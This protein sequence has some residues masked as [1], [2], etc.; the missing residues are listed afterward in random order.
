[1][2]SFWRS[3]R[4]HRRKGSRGFGLKFDHTVV[5][6]PNRGLSLIFSFSFYNTKSR[7]AFD[8]GDFLANLD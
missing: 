8:D 5:L 7:P 1:M 3:P 2:T 4:K 6:F